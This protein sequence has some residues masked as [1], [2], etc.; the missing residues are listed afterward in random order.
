MSQLSAG[1]VI[2]AAGTSTRMRGTDK[3]WAD[4]AGEPLIARTLHTFQSCTDIGGIAV[5]TSRDGLAPVTRLIRRAGIDKVSAVCEGGSSRQ[6]SVL[7]GLVKLGECE[8]VAVHDCARPLVTQTLIQHGLEVARARGAALCAVPAKNTIKVV[9][10][11]RVIDTPRREQLWEAQTPQV[12]RYRELLRAHV[13]AAQA[14]R[15]FTDDA[16]LMEAAGHAV[17]VYEGSYRNLKVT[18]P[19]DLLVVQALWE[20]EK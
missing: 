15:I 3:L 17:W 1:A 8:L 19:E 6:E 9:E 2:V 11:G 18:T 7:N 14:G 13:A 5:V 12:F 10:A 16:S 4:V 20:A